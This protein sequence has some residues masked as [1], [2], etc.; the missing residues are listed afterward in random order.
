MQDMRKKKKK[1]NSIQITG[2]LQRNMITYF[3]QLQKSPFSWL[4]PQA[5]MCR[6]FGKELVILFHQSAAPPWGHVASIIKKSLT[7]DSLSFGSTPTTDSTGP[8]R[9]SS[10]TA[11]FWYLPQPGPK[12][13]ERTYRTHGQL[14]SSRHFICKPTNLLHPLYP[15]LIKPYQTHFTKPQ[16]T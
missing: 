10:L 7:G 15:Y 2:N 1:K 3:E 12:S 6:N 9:S 8:F 14:S 16:Q 13:D 5:G 4:S 11:Y